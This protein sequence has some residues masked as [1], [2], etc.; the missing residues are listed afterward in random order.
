[1][2]DHIKRIQQLSYQ[3]SYIQSLVKKGQNTIQTK[4]LL[5]QRKTHNNY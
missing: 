2:V 4:Q 5:I 1:M 3:G